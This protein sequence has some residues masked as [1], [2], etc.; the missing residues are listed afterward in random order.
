[1]MKHAVL[2]LALEES[3]ARSYTTHIL[4]FE[5]EYGSVRAASSRAELV[6]RVL[7]YAA[8][9]LLERQFAKARVGVSALAHEVALC[10]GWSLFEH[11]AVKDFLKGLE[12]MKNLR[13][14]PA[15]KRDPLPAWAIVRFCEAAGAVPSLSMWDWVA[16][17]AIITVGVRCI[18][19]PGELADMRE[20]Q[21]ES[22]TFGAQVRIV[23]SKTDPVA[24]GQW[25][26]LEPGS[27]AACPIRCLRR[28][29][30]MAKG[31]LLEQWRP[32]SASRFFFTRA[33]GRPYSTENI[34]DFIRTL[35]TFAG[36]E[37]K[38]GGHSIRISGACL[39]VLGGMSLE[40]VKSIGG[41]RSNVVETYLRGLV[42]VAGEATTRM[43]L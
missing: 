21:L 10:W 14:L 2:S 37:G 28:Y 9:F 24:Q 36:L 40:Q 27:T 29:L 11:Q 32:G 33:N 7:A 17:C 39:A 18:R 26:P 42:A 15:A 1:M 30:M 3:T 35:A 38:F 8:D 5:D 13:S 23:L 31:Q 19:R 12:K 6:D 4:D 41:W 22:T 34:K 25:L 16:A 20:D 43:G